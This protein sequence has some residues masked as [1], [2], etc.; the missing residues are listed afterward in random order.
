MRLAKPILLALTLT[1]SAHSQTAKHSDT[2][3]PSIQVVTREVVLDV[4]VTDD[5]GNPVHNLKQEDFTVKEDN[6]PQPVRGFHEYSAETV[7]PPHPLPPNIYTNL[8]PP[9][10]SSAVN[11]V[12]LDGLNTA[13]ADATDPTSVTWSF[14]IQARVRQEVR[15]FLQ[16]MPPGTQMS[17]L[18]LSRNLR[19]LQGTT[20]NSALLSAAV[21]TMDINMDGR[22][23]T[24]PQWCAQQL[25]RNRATLEAIDQIASSSAAIKGKKNLI[26]FSTGLPTITDPSVNVQVQCN[27]GFTIRGSGVG[28]AAF[29]LLEPL[30]DLTPALLKTVSLLAAAEMTVYL[31]NPQATGSIANPIGIGIIDP[32]SR[33]FLQMNAEENLSLESIAEATGGEA[34]YNTNDLAGAM[35]K[36]VDKGANF[37]SIS[38]IPP[39]KKYDYGHHNLKVEVDRPNL[40]L[41]Y[42][43]TYDNIDP[44]TI[45]PLPALTLAA[46]IPAPSAGLQDPEAAKSLMRAAMS[47]NMPLSTGIL[48]DVQVQPSTEP[49]RPNDPPIFGILDPVVAAQTSGNAKFLTRYDFEYIFP[50]RQLTFAPTPEGNQKASLDFDLAAYDAQGKLVTSLSQTIQPTLTPTQQQ[51]LI[52]SPFRFFQQL[53]LPPGLLFL[54][55]GILDATAN[56]AGTLEIPLTVP[57]K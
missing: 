35:Q 30:P 6:K 8:Q 33:N 50:A 32:D 39:S 18:G 27:A 14:A 36:A 25:S 45:K 26:W 51:Q 48:F 40:H 19:V 11:L 56:K 34:Y 17:I 28:G 12:L 21:D 43:K 46:A 29:Q 1:L 23:L 10:A 20:S 44:A 3:T 4:T 22:A 41:V 9:P 55:I 24:P 54:R 16:S 2:S 37:Y 53:D 7:P 49:A 13:P 31:I 57:K 15:K 38:Y 52:K 47:R 5:Q 42:R